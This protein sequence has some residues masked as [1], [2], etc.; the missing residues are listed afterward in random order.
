MQN[1]KEKKFAPVKMPAKKNMDNTRDLQEPLQEDYRK[2]PVA[3][4]KKV[5]NKK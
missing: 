1:Q 5:K 2:D 4:N 3:I